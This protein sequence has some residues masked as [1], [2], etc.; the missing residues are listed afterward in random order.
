M[1]EIFIARIVTVSFFSSQQDAVKLL[2]CQKYMAHQ[3]DPM[4]DYHYEGKETVYLH[5]PSDT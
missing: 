4:Y 3:D 2:L 1:D 5:L